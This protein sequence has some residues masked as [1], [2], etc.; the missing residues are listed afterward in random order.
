MLE[1]NPEIPEAGAASIDMEAGGVR[2]ERR[3]SVISLSRSPDAT[4]RLGALCT[5]PGSARPTP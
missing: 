2:V 1:G 5:V 3:M 4:S